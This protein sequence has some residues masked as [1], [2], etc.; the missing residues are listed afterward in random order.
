M[1]LCDCERFVQLLLTHCG[2]EKRLRRGVPPRWRTG[3]KPEQSLHSKAWL[4]KRSE[5]GNKL[6]SE[7][8]EEGINNDLRGGRETVSQVG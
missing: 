4:Y 8:R 6:D 5:K 7:R 1:V 3:R 2:N